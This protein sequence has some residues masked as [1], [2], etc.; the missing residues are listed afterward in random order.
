[1]FSDLGTLG[2]GCGFGLVIYV[3]Y[4]FGQFLLRLCQSESSLHEYPPLVKQPFETAL[5]LSLVNS[6]AIDRLPRNLKTR[7][8][9]PWFYLGI[10]IF[11]IWYFTLYD[12]SI[13]PVATGICAVSLIA[14]GLV[15]TVCVRKTRSKR[16]LH[17]YG[18]LFLLSSCLI[19]SIL[20]TI[21]CGRLSISLILQK[22]SMSGMENLV[23]VPNL[24]FMA[25][26]FFGTIYSFVQY[27]RYGNDKLNRHEKE[28][29]ETVQ[30][31]IARYKPAACEQES[32][33]RPT[34]FRFGFWI[35]FCFGYAVVILLAFAVFSLFQEEIF[36]KSRML[37][38]YIRSRN[39]TALI[40]ME[41]TN[42]IHYFQR[43]CRE[44]NPQKAIED[45]DAAI[46]LNPEYMEA[47]QKR[48]GA[49]IQWGVD[50]T[51]RPV[52]NLSEENKARFLKAVADCDT[53]IR[54]DPK[55][56]EPWRIRSNAHQFLGDFDTALADVNQAI[57][58]KS[59]STNF[60]QRAMIYEAAGD[61]Q[62]ALADSTEAIRLQEENNRRYS[63]DDSEIFR[64]LD[65]HVKPYYRFR[66]GIY[67][68]LDEREK[69]Q[70]DLAKSK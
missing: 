58:I 25:L 1:M 47:Y 55:N 63:D 54:L 70:A 15:H 29:L 56:D 42:P 14:I 51:I 38:S 10:V 69:A 30:Q 67:E 34:Q 12:W 40:E 59:V 35:R 2:A 27:F 53:V 43:G 18:G 45:F 32:D 28:H 41:P 9:A 6:S 11:L 24:L 64:I 60:F 48:A 19:V 46:R 7:W 50:N 36:G 52:G 33:E 66:A 16:K 17:L 62:N 65:E 57:S 22:A 21:E 13:N 3:F 20:E 68:R 4:R 23:H 49:W 5:G 31:A 8:I 61:L 26:G 44:G 37:K 39:Y